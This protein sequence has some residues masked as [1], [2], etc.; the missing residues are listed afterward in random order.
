MKY[1]NPHPGR[2]EHSSRA[3]KIRK[4]THMIGFI[5]QHGSR[6]S[7]IAYSLDDARAT[8]E[9]ARDFSCTS[10]VISEDVPGRGW[11]EVS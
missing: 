2:Y 5:D 7:R 10:I 9:R 1:S 11:V 4:V 6:Q 8:A 3:R